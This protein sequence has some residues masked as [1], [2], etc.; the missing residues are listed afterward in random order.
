MRGWWHLIKCTTL[1]HDWGHYEMPGSLML[2]QETLKDFRVQQLAVVM[3]SLTKYGSKSLLLR[4]CIHHL[5]DQAM[6]T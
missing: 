4:G 2:I 5:K 1:L 6:R 3:V